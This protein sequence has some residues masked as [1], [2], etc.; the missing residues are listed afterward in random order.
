ML[1]TC[2]SHKHTQILPFLLLFLKSPPRSERLPPSERNSALL[3]SEFRGQKDR[4]RGNQ[5][6]WLE[7]RAPRIPV[8]FIPRPAV[9]CTTFF[10]SPLLR[11]NTNKVHCTPLVSWFDFY[12]ICLNSLHHFNYNFPL[13]WEKFSSAGVYRSRKANA[14]RRNYTMHA[15]FSVGSRVTRKNRERPVK[16]KWINNKGVLV[17]KTLFI[18]YPTC[19]CPWTSCVAIGWPRQPP[20]GGTQLSSS[21]W[22]PAQLPAA[23]LLP[24]LL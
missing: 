4:S 5:G 16:C 14:P 2:K 11:K 13:Q 19:K 21:P 12:Q 22:S 18:V 24:G 10:F 7:G 9:F 1:P 8:L 20:L 3:R 15:S 6:S 23:E 17:K